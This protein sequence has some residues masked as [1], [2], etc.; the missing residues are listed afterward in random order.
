MPSIISVCVR[1]Q[2]RLIKPIIN[3]LSIDTARSIQDKLGEFGEK[4]VAARINTTLVQMDGFEACFV[5]PKSGKDDKNI[6]LYLHGGGYV[7]GNLKYAR[8]FAGILAVETGRR[9]FSVA[10]RLAPENPFPAALE[11]AFAA[12]QYLL[13]QGYDAKNI[14]LVGE[15]AGG[16]LLY[17]LCLLLKQKGD[18]LPVSLVAISPWTDLTCSGSS[19]KTNIKKDPS[20][21]E[22]ALRLYAEAY[23]KGKERDPLVSPIYGDLSAFPPS[24]IFAGGDELLLDDSEMLTKEL[25]DGGS[26]SELVVEDGL[27]HVYVLFKIPEAG[28]ALNRISEFLNQWS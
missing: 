14:S 26:Q 15:S 11:D 22:K 16:G 25:T 2:I 24:L 3:K 7:A 21:S 4:T 1:E 10:Y 17:A 12:Y 27:W 5:S 9:V 8:G 20:L 23:A 18:K 19:Y 6:I 13:K 28:K